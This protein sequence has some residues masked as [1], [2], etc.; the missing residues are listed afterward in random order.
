[1]HLG[2]QVAEALLAARANDGA[3]AP[4]TYRP[5]T[6]AGTYVPTAPVA[7]ASWSQVTP[8]AL[9]QAAQFRPPAPVPLASA[10]WTKDFDE[11]KRMGAK[12]SSAR[13]PEQTELARVWELT[14]PPLHTPVVRQLAARRRLDLLDSARLFALHAIAMADSYV[15][16]FDAKYTYNFWRP[17]TAIR[18]GDADGEPRHRARGRVGAVHCDANASRVSVCTLHQQRRGCSRAGSVLR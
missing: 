14:G 12:N 15:A 18:N 6:T 8:F 11:V 5:H 13:T 16:V 2:Q 9:K 3:N 7:A 1:M 4:N 17:V 10:Q